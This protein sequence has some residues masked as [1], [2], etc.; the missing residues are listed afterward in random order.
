[1]ALEKVFLRF[2][3][4]YGKSSSYHYSTR[5]YRLSMRCAVALTK[6]H[7]II[8]SVLTGFI[9]ELTVDWSRDVGN[10]VFNK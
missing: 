9:C 6:Q 1:V 2:S 4:F 5:I 10:L 7:L 3:V 8:P